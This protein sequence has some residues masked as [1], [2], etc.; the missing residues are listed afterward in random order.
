VAHLDHLCTRNHPVII[1]TDPTNHE[2][3][4]INPSHRPIPV[5]I[6]MAKVPFGLTIFRLPYILREPVFQFPSRR[7][8]DGMPNP[9]I[10]CNPVPPGTNMQCPMEVIQ[11][12]LGA[13]FAA[14]ITG[15]LARRQQLAGFRI[16]KIEPVPGSSMDQD[17]TV[18]T[19][20]KR[21]RKGH[22]VTAIVATI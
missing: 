6:G 19:S 8:T 14:L 15:R 3:P 10:V 22:C 12:M 13:F 21:K 9:A 1:S 2:S 17:R 5:I 11:V 16:R 4:L 7:I 20:S 18:V